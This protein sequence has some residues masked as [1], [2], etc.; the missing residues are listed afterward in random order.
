MYYICIYT[1][2]Y[3]WVKWDKYIGVLR[4]I[5]G[6]RFKAKSPS[7]QQLSAYRAGFG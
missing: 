6:L 3:R 4:D 5:C 2:V 7:T 1:Y